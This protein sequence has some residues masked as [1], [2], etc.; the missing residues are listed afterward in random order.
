MQDPG[1]AGV[2]GGYRGQGNRKRGGGEGS[3]AAEGHEMERKPYRLC[4]G[5]FCC[6]RC[7]GG[8]QVTKARGLD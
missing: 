5:L 7:D 1:A 4:F 2:S 3:R 6:R 8:L